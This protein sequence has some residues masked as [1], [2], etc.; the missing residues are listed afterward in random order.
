MQIMRNKNAE[1]ITLALRHIFEY[2]NGV[3]HT[4]WFDNDT[5]LVKIEIEENHIKK[6]TIC[7]TF[8][9]FKLYYDFQEVFLNVMRTNE[10]GTVE[11]GVRFMRRNLLVPLP[12]FDDF[13]A[14]NKELLEESKNLLKREHYALKHSII[15]LH[16]EDIT[17]LN[18]LPLTA[19]EPSSISTKKLDNYGRLTTEGRLYY[20]LSPSYAYKKIQVKFLS[21]ALEIYYEDGRQ[22]MNVPRLS[23]AKGARYINWSPYIRLL[24]VKPA[25]MYNFSFLDLFEGRDDIIEKITKLEGTKL[26]LFLYSFANI[27][28]DVGIDEAVKKVSTLL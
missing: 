22:I 19:F 28:D 2:L 4:I 8:Q 17:E 7:D 9:R 13:D 5:V 10:K 26:Q 6:R 16:Y 3:P 15:D 20:Y 24:S 27:I 14:F 11:Q 23:A 12:S 18:P 21:D 1:S 25:A